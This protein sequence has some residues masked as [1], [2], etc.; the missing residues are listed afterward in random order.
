MV[1]RRKTLLTLIALVVGGFATYAY[2]FRSLGIEGNKLF[3]E[4]CNKVNPALI[5]YKN[6][7]L[8]FMGIIG[9]PSEHT[10]EEVLGK[11][12]EYYQGVKNYIPLE[13]E[14]TGKQY[15]FVRGW[16]FQ[17]F[18]PDY[19]RKLGNYQLEMYQSYLDQ[20]KAIVH[21]I[22]GMN[23]PD[24]TQSETR[25]NLDIARKT[26][27]TSNRYFT[28]YDE[29]G[30]RRDWRKVLLGSPPLNCPPE[31]LIIPDTSFEAIFPSPTPPEDTLK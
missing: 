27:E 26:M 28:A 20:A 21:V 30:K 31:N 16:G 14:W 12:Y 22:D 4:R 6:S 9:S 23:D 19:V 17:L 29:A 24:Q 8:E 2:A 15:A 25:A 3:E 1:V 7:Y 18:M 5:S 10:Q 11:M 13:E